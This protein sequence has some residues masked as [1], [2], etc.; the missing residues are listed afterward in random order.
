[1]VVRDLSVP[2]SRKLR[3]ID[4]EW[5]TPGDVSSIYG[6]E[7]VVPYG[8]DDNTLSFEN[9]V[10]SDWVV[11]RYKTRSAKGEIFNNPLTTVITEY[12]DV[13][14]T[15]TDER[16]NISRPDS[17]QTSAVMPV[18][19]IRDGTMPASALIGCSAYALSF[20]HVPDIDEVPLQQLAVTGAHAN[21]DF[22]EASLYE[23]FGEMDET[24]MFMRHTFKRAIR[25]FRAVRKKEL[26]FL[27]KE[28]K[29]KELRDRY[30]EYR[31]AVRPLVYDVRN[32]VSAFTVGI[33]GRNRFTFRKTER[34]KETDRRTYTGANSNWDAVKTSSREVVCV[35]GVLTELNDLSQSQIWGLDRPLDA[36]WELTP[37]S[38]IADWFFNI[39]QT[40]SAF[41][42]NP[43]V[44]N[45]A[46]WVTT[47]TIECCEIYAAAV[48]VQ[49]GVYT[50]SDTFTGSDL[51]LSKKVTTKVRTPSP[52]LSI[53]PRF[54]LKLD[55]W[56]L[57]DLAIIG[58]TL[59][60]KDRE[61]A[62]KI[63]MY[64]RS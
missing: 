33:P 44:K 52:T 27:K 50:W 61:K 25:I 49:R 23:T 31:Y 62:L 2:T 26:K 42:P 47:S 11:P 57:L 56:K 12:E 58:K 59:F 14:V 43:G 3:H 60:S 38:F 53:M 19:D 55:A 30:M 35:A 7:N 40:I 63:A 45:L 13:A 51:F 54:K 21:I 34:S 5:G 48:S 1:M 46:S 8:S 10:M 28:I 6:T 15:L 16:L 20:E 32:A 64:R 22:S 36:M 29:L 41:A 37:F 18:G 39:G 4:Y 17:G 9:K 24:V